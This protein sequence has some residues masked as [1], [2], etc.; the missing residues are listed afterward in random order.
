MSNIITIST[1][2]RESTGKSAAH[3]I[4]KSGFVPAVVYGH[5][6]ASAAIQIS[7]AELKTMFKKGSGSAGDYRLF[8]LLIQQNGS[9]TD[10]MVVIKDIQRH[11]ITGTIEH[12]DFLSVKMDEEITAPVQIQVIGK[13]EGVKSGG[14]LRQ[15]LREIEVRSLPDK[16]PP[17]IDI[18]IS[19]LN[20]GDSIHVSDL[21]I[22]GEVELLTAPDETVITILAPA[23]EKEE[24]EE[25]EEAAEAAESPAEEA[26]EAG[27]GE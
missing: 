19:H 6:F 25:A 17:H 1:K 16:I 21:S 4:R 15:I 13:P 20:I 27:E 12:I 10:T 26:P 5:S 2:S 22:P 23:A 7:Q 9:T 8:K 11:P 3:K 14:I 24:E 18:D